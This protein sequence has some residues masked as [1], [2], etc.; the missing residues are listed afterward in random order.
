M[1]GSRQARVWGLVAASAASRSRPVSAADACAAV[2]P[3]VEVSGAWLMAAVAGDAGHV[4]D[5]VLS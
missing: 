3:A 1:T 4:L 2:V 5:V